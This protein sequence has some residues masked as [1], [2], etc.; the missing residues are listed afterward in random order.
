MIF[1]CELCVF[2][3]ILMVPWFSSILGLA[4]FNSENL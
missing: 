4:S 3:A 2:V 1:L